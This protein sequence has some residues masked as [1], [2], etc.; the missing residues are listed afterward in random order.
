MVK[1]SVV[2]ITYNS[3]KTLARTIESVLNQTCDDYE[4]L[5][6]DGAS[7][8][9]TIDIIRGY[10][11]KFNGRLK[12]ISKKDGG[13]YEAMN[14]GIK[15][16]R[17]VIVG[18]VNSDD[19]LEPNALDQINEAYCSNTSYKEDTLYCGAIW[20]HY[21][22]G[23]KQL[24]G[25]NYKRFEKNI[26]RGSLKGIWHPGTFVPKKIYN[27]VG[28]FDEHFRIIGDVDFIYRCYCA[29]KR[30]KLLS[31]TVS[32]MT[33]GGASYNSNRKDND[34]EYYIKKHNLFQEYSYLEKSYFTALSWI[35][36]KMPISIIR[37]YR[38]IYTR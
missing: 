1:F 34:G 35:K 27:E 14:K 25:T 16:A 37:I 31:I 4:Y 12:W 11:P 32:N 5:I 26:K 18:I 6:I 20:F 28:L 38:S 3:S 36:R 17:G 22:D 23:K 29:G 10:E 30:F 9:N 13:I 21:L 33:D 15:M 2:T 8:D 19:Y 24:F 7:S